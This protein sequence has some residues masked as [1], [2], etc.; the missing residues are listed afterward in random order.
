M[1]PTSG[2]WPAGTVLTDIYGNEWVVQGAPGTSS[3]SVKPQAI[4]IDTVIDTD[5]FADPRQPTAA[6][7]GTTDDF[8]NVIEAGGTIVVYPTGEKLC[9]PPKSNVVDTNTFANP[10]PPTDAELGTT[11]DFGNV[12]EEGGT[13][14]VYPTGEKLC[15]PAKID[16]APDTFADPRP[17]TN[18]EIGQTDD[19]GNIIEDGGTIIDFPSGEKLCV[20]PK[21]ECKPEIARTECQITCNAMDTTEWLCDGT[22]RRHVNNATMG[23]F[24]AVNSSVI[25]L[26]EGDAGFVGAPIALPVELAWCG[27]G[28]TVLWT[29]GATSA[30]P[31]DQDDVNHGQISFEPL[32]NFNGG[33]PNGGMS[34][35]GSMQV[36]PDNPGSLAG[37]TGSGDAETNFVG[38]RISPTFSGGANVN[39]CVTRTVVVD[40]NIELNTLVNGGVVRS[41]V[42]SMEVGVVH[43]VKCDIPVDQDL[44]IGQLPPQ[45]DYE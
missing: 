33:V 27:S 40:L 16:V 12:I 31:N 15:V 9:V 30:V 4:E 44:P 45:P 34:S 10:R 8:G 17:P 11:D 7:I 1:F 13:V 41:N 38:L 20:P 5:T 24:R 29:G 42:T 43:E 18:A 37:G 23:G 25:E 21:P 35:G 6:E 26:G 3:S 28:M 32:I 22:V 2:P 14:V 39:A 36:A 19:F